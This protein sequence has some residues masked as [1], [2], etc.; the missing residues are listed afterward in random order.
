MKGFLRITI[1]LLFWG[2]WVI[3]RRPRYQWMAA[4]LLRLWTGQDVPAPA[5]AQEAVQPMIERVVENA[6][7]YGSKPWIHSTDYDSSG[8]YGRPELFYLVGG[9]VLEVT[10]HDDHVHVTARDVYDWHPAETEGD[11]P[12]WFV[13]P[14]PVR[15]PGE[16][17]WC[18]WD[19]FGHTFFAPAFDG[20]L[21]VSNYLWWWLDGG[22]FTT[23][24]EWRF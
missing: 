12:F 24:M 1:G 4:Y 8:F 3:S 5:W 13:S 11:E 19:V 18:T 10:E 21:G 7:Y 2:L 20:A 16:W 17:A 6:L 9:F 15:L 14:L 22:E 23:V